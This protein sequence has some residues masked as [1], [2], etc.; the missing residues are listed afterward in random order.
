[1][2]PVKVQ[3]AK[4]SSVIVAVAVSAAVLIAI[5]ASPDAIVVSVIVTF[6]MPS[7]TASSITVKSMVS[8][9]VPAGNVIVPGNATKSFPLDAVP[10]TV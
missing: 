6:S 9:V 3:I 5:S 7:I 2:V 10:V 8:V 1:M 4:S